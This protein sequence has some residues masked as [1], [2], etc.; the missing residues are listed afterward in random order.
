[1]RV[2]SAARLALGFG[3]FLTFSQ[4]AIVGWAL[5]Q[6]G[7]R[8]WAMRVGCRGILRAIG[9]RSSWSGL[10]HVPADGGFVL[11]AN[12]ESHIDGV[13]L[14][15][16]VPRYL[17]VVAK[18]EL[19]RAPIVGTVF[20]VLDFIELDRKRADKARESLGIG[21]RRVADGSAALIFPE[22]TRSADG[23]LRDFKKGAVI[24]AIQAGVPLLP[25]GIAGT[26]EAFPPTGL[27]LN[28]G[29]CHFVVGEP[30]STEG[31]TLADRDALNERL[32]RAVAELRARAH[33]HLGLEA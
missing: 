8:Y 3:V 32:E 18:K 20:R 13:M 12:H 33:A 24:M 31:A 17:H 26:W 11:A 27:D 25:V 2:S 15:S 28:P 19:F 22:G 10:E 7:L 4:P 29:P 6:T 5:G 9:A 1:M 21:T 16:Y 14:V 23:G 30:I